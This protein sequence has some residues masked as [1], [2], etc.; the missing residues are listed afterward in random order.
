MRLDGR[1]AQAQTRPL[2]DAERRVAYLPEGVTSPPA[3]IPR[4]HRCSMDS[5]VRIGGSPGVQVELGGRGGCRPQ[6][7]R[8]IRRSLGSAA[9]QADFFMIHNLGLSSPLQFNGT[10]YGQFCQPRFGRG[11]KRA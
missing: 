11:D 4:R 9:W 7:P 10:V 8:F 3:A 1:E 2:D 5:E 6:T